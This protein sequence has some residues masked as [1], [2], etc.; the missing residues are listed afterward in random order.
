VK[1]NFNQVGGVFME[2]GMPRQR[3]VCPI[4]NAINTMSNSK[5]YLNH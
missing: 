2:A 1:Q 3:M 4:E 5:Y